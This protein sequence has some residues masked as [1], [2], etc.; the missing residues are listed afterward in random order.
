MHDFALTPELKTIL[1]QSDVQTWMME[2][3]IGSVAPA[4]QGD[5]FVL[6][7]EID[8][9]AEAFRRQWLAG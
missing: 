6:R 8:D 1:Q 9:E 2:H 7:F 4:W 3:C 5:E